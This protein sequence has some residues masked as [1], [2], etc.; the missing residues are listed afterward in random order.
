[1][2]NC[3]QRTV[4]TLSTFWGVMALEEQSNKLQNVILL[5]VQQIPLLTALDCVKQ[6]SG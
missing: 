5:R 6:Q 3:P 4:F 2:L 1:M